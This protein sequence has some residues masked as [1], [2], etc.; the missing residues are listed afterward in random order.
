MSRSRKISHPHQC[1]ML[2]RLKTFSQRCD[3]DIGILSIG[4]LLDRVLTPNDIFNVKCFFLVLIWY[5]PKC[6]R[7]VV[8]FAEKG[9]VL[10]P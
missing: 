6:H 5:I 2:H 8:H 1:Y 4:Q 7:R 9:K 10:K 3:I